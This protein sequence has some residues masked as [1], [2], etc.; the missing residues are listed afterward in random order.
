[1]I[2]PC[3]MP[4]SL[5]ETIFAFVSS[6]HSLGGVKPSAATSLVFALYLKRAASSPDRLML[7]PPSHCSNVGTT[8]VVYVG[9]EAGGEWCNRK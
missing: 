8:P 2:R 1:M 3:D 5:N 7:L 9:A 6:D 4:C